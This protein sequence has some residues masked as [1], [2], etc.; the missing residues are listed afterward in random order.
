M[1]KRKKVTM[2]HLYYERHFKGNDELSH[3]LSA[4]SRLLGNNGVAHKGNFSILFY[5]TFATWTM[6][7]EIEIGR[8]LPTFNMFISK[9]NHAQIRSYSGNFLS[10]SYYFL[11][12]WLALFSPKY[13]KV[14]LK[15][16]RVCSGYQDFCRKFPTVISFNIPE[17]VEL[18]PST[19]HSI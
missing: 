1:E 17:V 2:W 7:S 13:R 9:N 16:E 5:S 11:F 14:L 19:S 18:A 8:W 10:C 15:G 12:F 4:S 3:Y 6:K